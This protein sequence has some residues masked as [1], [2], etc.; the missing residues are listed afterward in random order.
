[1]LRDYTTMSKQQ[2][3]EQLARDYQAYK[4]KNEVELIAAETS[5]LEHRMI[6]GPNPRSA[7][8]QRDLRQ[9]SYEAWL[10]E[11]KAQQHNQHA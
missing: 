9:E 11:V 6:C 2:L 1:M 10:A 8:K 5:P 3:R 4:A 7:A